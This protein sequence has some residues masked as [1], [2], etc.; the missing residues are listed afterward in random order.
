MT[1]EQLDFFTAESE[2]VAEKASKRT[3]KHAFVGY[4]ALFIGVMLM[5]WNGQTVSKHERFEIR[6]AGRA[7]AI[8]SC[9]RDYISREEIRAVLQASKKE[10]RLA[11]ER[12]ELS[13]DAYRRAVDFFNERLNRLP[14]P[15]CDSSDDALAD[16][17]EPITLPEPLTP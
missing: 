9:N 16:P 6:Q 10:R 4:I 13:E 14:L 11:L 7:V 12:G 5:Y 2:R 1:R 8:H 3:I 17:E 15:N